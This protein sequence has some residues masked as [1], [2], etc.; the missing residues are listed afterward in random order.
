MGVLLH[1][2]TYYLIHFQC[3]PLLSN[4]NDTVEVWVVV[5]LFWPDIGRDCI[6]WWL[7]TYEQIQPLYSLNSIVSLL[8]I[9]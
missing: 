5:D 4:E 2:L 9:F 8:F 3:L 6:A 7:V 1:G